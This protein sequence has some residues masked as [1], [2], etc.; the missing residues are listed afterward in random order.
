LRSKQEGLQALFLS[1]EIHHCGS[2]DRNLQDR[3]KPSKNALS[4]E[5]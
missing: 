5:T 2:V 1:V 4:Q 3:E